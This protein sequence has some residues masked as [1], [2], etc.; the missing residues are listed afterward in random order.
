MKHLIALGAAA[1][2]TAGTASAA[3]PSVQIPLEGE[4]CKSCTISAFLNGPF[5]SLDMTTTSI[6]GSESLTINC[7]YGGSA[8]V[9]FSSLN[10]GKMVSNGNE[11]PY[12]FYVIGTSLNAGVSLATDQTT[13]F[14]AVLN[15]NQT[16][17]LKVSLDTPAVAAGVYGDLITASVTPN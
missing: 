2:L 4:L 17:T 3:P 8:T 7:N 1:L 15:A 12:K 10:G 9:K 14:P 13:T 5:D 6:Q 11:V 16:R